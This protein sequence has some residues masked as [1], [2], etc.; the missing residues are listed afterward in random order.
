[1]QDGPYNDV[2]TW[3]FHRLPEVFGAGRSFLVRTEDELDRALHEAHAW[4]ESF[5]LIEVILDPHDHSPALHRLTD[6]LGKKI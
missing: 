3:R 2:A 5:A 1:M 6:G 4:R